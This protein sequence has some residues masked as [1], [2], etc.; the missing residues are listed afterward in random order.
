M[1]NCMN[2]MNIF[3]IKNIILILKIITKHKISNFFINN[4][5]KK[6]VTCCKIEHFEYSLQYI[7]CNI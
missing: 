6:I 5:F 4:N 7:C 1:F 3:Y 2:Y